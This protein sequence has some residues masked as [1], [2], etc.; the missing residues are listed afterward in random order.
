MKTRITRKAVISTH[1]AVIQVGYCD[2]QRLLNHEQPYAYT[3]G[4]EGWNA[5]VYSFGSVAIVTG[6]RA[7]G[8]IKP[9]H[10]LVA[11]YEVK[12]FAIDESGY[13]WKE[14]K[15]LKRDLIT[16]FITEVAK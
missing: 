16:E 8:D 2:L 15:K 1:T 9:P 3:A 10:E 13:T 4:S 12:A 6:Y 7:F 14:R 5:D 11:L